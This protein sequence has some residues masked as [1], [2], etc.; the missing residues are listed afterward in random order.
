M[1]F[2]SLRALTVATAEEQE[3]TTRGLQAAAVQAAAAQARTDILAAVAEL[4]PSQ[5]PSDAF[6]ATTAGSIGQNR[7][8]LVVDHA[9]P[10]FGW[11]DTLG[12][13]LLAEN[14]SLC[15][16]LARRSP[17]YR[18]EGAD[19]LGG[20]RWKPVNLRMPPLSATNAARVCLR[21]VHR[22]LT[23]SD[24][25]RN[26]TS[27]AAITPLGPAA[28]LPRL[29]QHPALVACQGNPREIVR[30]ASAI[31]PELPSLLDYVAVKVAA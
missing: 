30:V 24:F 6:A 12:A 20:D 25:S 22:P 29:A 21:R 13:K 27:A 11:Q 15:L 9:D 3:R 2:I 8:C 16:L 5:P 31:T 18:L 23:E 4:L 19:S 7:C 14:P 28:L 17:L 1:A 26:V 10:E